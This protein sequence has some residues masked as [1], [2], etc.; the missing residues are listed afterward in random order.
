MFVVIRIEDL[1]L[2]EHQFLRDIQIKIESCDIE[3]Q[4]FNMTSHDLIKYCNG[5]EL[6]SEKELCFNEIQSPITEPKTDITNEVEDLLQLAELV[7]G[8][9]KDNIISIRS[10]I[11]E[12]FNT[13]AENSKV[14]IA[15]CINSSTNETISLL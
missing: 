13:A 4:K 10:V 1:T 15:K 8:N 14:E 11:N 9:T 3:V 6:D 7:L 12:S 5:I 2:T